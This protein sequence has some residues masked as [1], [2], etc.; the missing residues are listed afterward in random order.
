MNLNRAAIAIS[1]AASSAGAFS[2]SAFLGRNMAVTTSVHSASAAPSRTTG[3]VMF[4]GN[5]FGGAGAF[6]QQIEYS[7]LPWPG[8]ELGA[9]AQQGTVL[10]TS[11]KKPNLELATF[12]GGCF[13]GLELA[14][15]RVPGVEYTAV[16]YTQGPEENPNYEQVC[17]GATGHTEALVVYY[18]PND[19]SFD[20]LLDTF[21]ERVNPTTVNGQGNDFGTQY[22]TGVYFHTPAQEAAARERF[23][24][25]QENYQK[26]IA[27]ELKA[28]TPFWP[29][30]KYHQQYLEKGGRFNQ[31]QDASKGATDT[32]R[33]YG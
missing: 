28:A 22:R 2:R 20:A 11:P 18:N 29:A 33:C 4:F 23:A 31:P 17:S 25:E 26:P 5:L 8:D 32:I 3:T 9:A 7:N 13:W 10:T 30:E 27:T 12:A 1:L 24:K 6:G 15:Q 16:G 14:F 21:F 19:T